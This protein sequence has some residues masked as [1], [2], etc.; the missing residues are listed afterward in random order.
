M[1]N[2]NPRA[3]SAIDAIRCVYLARIAA[4]GGHQEAARRWQQMATAWLSQFQKCTG[5]NNR[6]KGKHNPAAPGKSKADD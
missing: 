1:N 6:S 2:D 3:N 4:Q 5:K